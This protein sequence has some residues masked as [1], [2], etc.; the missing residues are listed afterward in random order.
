MD[1]AELKADTTIADVVTKDIR[2]AKVFRKYGIDFCCGGHKPI[3][4]VCEKKNLDFNALMTDLSRIEFDAK[5]GAVDADKWE[6]DFLASYIVNIHHKYVR[7]TLPS[8]EAWSA[9]VAK[10]HGD[11][12]PE[13]IRVAELVNEISRELMGHMHK[14]E[15]ILFPS[16]VRIV[17]ALKGEDTAGFLQIEHP[18]EVMEHEHESVGNMYKE[19]ETLTSNFTPPSH[20]CN[21]F[22]ALY[23]LL[24]EFEDDLFLH[25]HLENNILFPKA[26]KLRDQL[27]TR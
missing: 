20:A 1:T 21:T 3:K 19:I 5:S 13:T 25:I 27:V 8:L 2:T 7:E 12:N 24:K 16:I 4:E 18:I 22:R 26:L 9:K 6:L 11:H 17:K 15:Q 10:V 14:E 23:N